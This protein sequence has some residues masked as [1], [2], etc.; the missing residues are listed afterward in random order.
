MKGLVRLTLL[1]D[2]TSDRCLL[3][4]LRYL[5]GSLVNDVVIESHWADLR[6]VSPRPAGLV[7]RIA[8]TIKYYPSDILFVHRDA[9]R[10]PWQ[11]RFT[12][13]RDA[14]TK[15]G[16]ALWAAV[17]P[18]R[19]TEAWLLLDEYAIRHAADNPTGTTPLDLPLSG[20]IEDDP[21]PKET[22]H[23]ALVAASDKRGRRLRRF[24]ETISSRV[25]R[26]AE[27]IADYDCLQALPAYRRT[28]ADAETALKSLG[29]LN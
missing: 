10:Q 24:R 4:I 13:I 2:G 18:V 12:E 25:H 9:E 23:A 16:S 5:V 22:L 21:D 28:R 20:R 26:V 3:G 14:A 1:G 29:Y 6:H 7:E 8:A 11:D 15:A 27:L 19:M 17:I